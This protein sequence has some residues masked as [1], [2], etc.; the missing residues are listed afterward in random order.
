M[1]RSA[2]KRKTSLIRSA[3]TNRISEAQRIRNAEWR[4]VCAKRA[5][6][7][8]QLCEG[9]IEGFCTKWGLHGHHVI[10]RTQGGPNTF[11]NC[12]WVCAACHTWIHA[13][14][15]KARS[16]GLLA[17]A[18]GRQS[19][20]PPANVVTNAAVCSADD[21]RPAAPSATARRPAA[22]AKAESTSDLHG[23]G[24]RA[25]RAVAAPLNIVTMRDPLAWAA[26][27]GIEFRGEVR[28]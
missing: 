8:D 6:S 13:N 17:S 26:A 3:L 18:A 1:K 20:R 14:P 23:A 24:A 4:R 2:L 16:L 9:G 19:A 21:V 28:A 7:V 15:T 10:R 22:I 12:R 11:D 25:A 5:E 27:E